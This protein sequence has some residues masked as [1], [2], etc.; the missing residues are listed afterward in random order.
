[1]S[2]NAT[3]ADERTEIR[4]HKVVSR[5]EWVNARKKLLRKEKQETALRDELSAERRRLPWVKIEKDYVFSGANSEVSLSELFKG[6]NQLLIY[7]F[8]F[9]PD[10]NEGC[11]SCSFLSDH[12]DAALP[13]LAA[14]D[15]QVVM[16]S[17]AP[18]AK[19]QAFK[20]RMGWHFDWVSSNANDF[21]HDFNVYFTDAEMAKG[22]VYY[23]YTMQP[24]PS[25]EAPGVSIF[26]KN[27]D[28]DIFHT[29]STFG[30]GLDAVV[31]A[32][33]LLDMV[34]KGRDEDHLGFSMEWV[35]HHDRYGT[36]EFADPNKPYWPEIA[37]TASPSCGCGA[38]EKKS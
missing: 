34:P 7:H 30:R 5:E 17:R 8:M 21:N 24:F 20:R 13:H 6:R 28:G 16:V 3:L 32:Y 38:G 35:R 12:I 22:E 18:I 2:M 31:G 36:D 10:W 26:Y 4:E 14:R 29:Y 1:M 19:I 25:Q 15:V 11:P 33:V 23:N 37:K 27:A 9:G